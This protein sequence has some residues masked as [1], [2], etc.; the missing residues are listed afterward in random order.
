MGN[1]CFTV[2][3]NRCVMRINPDAFFDK[4]T[5]VDI[6]KLFR[7]IF[8]EPERNT[9]T[10]AA[11]SEYLHAKVDESKKVWNEASVDYTNCFVAT[12]FYWG[13]P[14]KEKQGV[15]RANKKLIAAVKRAKAKHERWQKIL[16]AFETVKNKS[17]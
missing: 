4:S 12:Q 14:T 10:I 16:T 8:Q 15:E 11:L 1:E 17:I 5:L 13:L 3:V 6:R 7:Y 9:E 2:L